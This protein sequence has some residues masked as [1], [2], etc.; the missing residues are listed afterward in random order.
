MYLDFLIDLHLCNVWFPY[1]KV[2][3]DTNSF[4]SPLLPSE[5]HCY[6]NQLLIDA[7]IDYRHNTKIMEVITTLPS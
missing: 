4:I 2:V 6:T 1:E 3:A 5:N 7:Q